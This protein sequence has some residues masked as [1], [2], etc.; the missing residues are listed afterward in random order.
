[1]NGVE[2]EPEQ[3]L[4]DATSIREAMRRMARYA[5]DAAERLEALTLDV[6]EELDADHN[7][8]FR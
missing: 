6:S 7:R 2:P 8:H 4:E 3:I 5:S 1:V